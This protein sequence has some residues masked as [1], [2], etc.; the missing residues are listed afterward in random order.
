MTAEDDESATMPL[1]TDYNDLEEGGRLKNDD[2]ITS[3]NKNDKNEEAFTKLLYYSFW[4]GICVGIFVMDTSRHS[5]NLQ[6]HIP[7]LNADNKQRYELLTY[8][9]I[10][11]SYAFSL[12]LCYM[13][14]NLVFVASAIGHQACR[15]GPTLQ[16]KDDDAEEQQQAAHLEQVMDD[17]AEVYSAGYTGVMSVTSIWSARMNQEPPFSSSWWMAASMTLQ[18]LIVCIYLSFLFQ[19]TSVSVMTR[20]TGLFIILGCMSVVERS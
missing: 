17:M 15:G 18:A 20:V 16:G 3:Q 6:A 19:M 4:A 2:E 7:W 11:Y 10:L 1:L 12:L 14:R 9:L 5:Q 13:L 8:I